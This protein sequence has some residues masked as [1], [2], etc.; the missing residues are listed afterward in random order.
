MKFVQN[1]YR[2]SRWQGLVLEEL[3]NNLA[4]V[5]VIKTGRGHTANRRIVL[6]RNLGWFNLIPKIDIENINKD[7]ISNDYPKVIQQERKRYL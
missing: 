3:K 4:I 6:M 2:K 7:W 1:K 5:L